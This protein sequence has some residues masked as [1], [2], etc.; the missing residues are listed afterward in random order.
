[1]HRPASQVA[2]ELSACIRC[3][4][5]LNACPALAVPLAVEA[6]NRQTLNGPVAPEVARFA[7]NCILCGACV[8]VC[9]AGLHRDAMMLWLKLRLLQGDVPIADALPDDEGDAIPISFSPVAP[10][11]QWARGASRLGGC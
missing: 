6:V 4:E 9:P 1:M 3:N 5:C 7:Q 8:P 11:G 10:R 2:Q